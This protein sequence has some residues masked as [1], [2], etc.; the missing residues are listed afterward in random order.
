MEGWGQV[1]PEQAQAVKVAVSGGFG[2]GVAVFLRHPGSFLRGAGMLA[3]GVGAAAIFAEDAAALIGMGK[4]QAGALVGLLGKG[5]A[6]GLLR[7]V[8]RLDFGAWL[9]GR[10]KSERK[11]G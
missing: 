8:E 2:A 4:I 10:A 5:V 6:E 1:A 3:I 11:G 7:A 9:P